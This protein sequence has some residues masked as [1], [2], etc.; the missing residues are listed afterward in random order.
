MGE[1]ESKQQNMT[2]IRTAKD[3]EGLRKACLLGRE[4]LDAAARIIKCVLF[5]ACVSS[6]A[7]RPCHLPPS[8]RI[9]CSPSSTLLVHCSG[10]TGAA[11]PG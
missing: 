8:I 5:A 3:I 1:M 7:C 10:L 11:D 6:P 2:P 4:A 9:A